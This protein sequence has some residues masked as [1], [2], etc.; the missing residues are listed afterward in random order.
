MVA[1]DRCKNKPAPV[2]AITNKMTNRLVGLCSKNCI[3]KNRWLSV[4]GVYHA[5]NHKS[6]MDILHTESATIFL[7]CVKEWTNEW[8]RIYACSQESQTH[9][10]T[11]AALL[12]TK[13]AIYTYNIIFCW[14]RLSRAKND[15]FVIFILLQLQAFCW[16]PQ[17]SCCL[18]LCLYVSIYISLS[19][20]LF[21]SYLSS[22]FIEIICMG[23]FCLLT[24]AIW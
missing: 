12:L 6:S 18:F 22:A 7:Y 15:C 2:V 11:H 9:T 3:S 1:A 13:S 20:L 24:A 10:H 5:Y 21:L 4:F 23:C 8:V 17:F 14:L 16:S 19:L